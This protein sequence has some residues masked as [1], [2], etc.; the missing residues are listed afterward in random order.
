[1]LGSMLRQRGGVASGSRRLSSFAESTD[2]FFPPLFAGSGVA[3][4]DK[5][6]I[7]TRFNVMKAAVLGKADTSE[8]KI[9]SLPLAEKF[10]ARRLRLQAMRYRDHLVETGKLA[11][12]EK[13]TGDQFVVQKLALVKDPQFLEDFATGKVGT[14]STAYAAMPDWGKEA[15]ATMKEDEHKVAEFKS[16]NPESAENMEA[17]VAEAIDAQA[18][19]GVMPTCSAPRNPNTCLYTIEGTPEYDFQWR[20]YQQLDLTAR[21]PSFKYTLSAEDKEEAAK[22]NEKLVDKYKQFLDGASIDVPDNITM[23]EK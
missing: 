2:K 1:M 21:T 4:K 19:G 13:L 18:D 15:L 23:F 12:F 5:E 11:E 16:K 6:A 14:D 22:Y 7:A 17:A 10:V 20:F 9:K 8:I 3:N